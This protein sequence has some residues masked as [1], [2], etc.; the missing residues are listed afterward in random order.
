MYNPVHKQRFVVCQWTGESF[1]ES[2]R[3]LVPEHP[4]VR[5]QRSWTGCYGSPGAAVSGIKERSERIGLSVD[6][7]HELIDEFETSLSRKPG[8]GNVKFTIVAA[9]DYKNLVAFGGTQ[10]IEDFH[11]LYNHDGQ[12]E[13]YCQEIP[14]SPWCDAAAEGPVPEPSKA[15]ASAPK[16][17][18]QRWAEA[19]YESDPD[20]PANAPKRCCQ[21]SFLIARALRLPMLKVPDLSITLAPPASLTMKP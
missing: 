11:K 12:V 7:I 5:G 14:N 17:V 19:E 4:K 13:I 16:S 2:Q 18:A 15:P 1:P 20:R 21:R 10:S 3:F 6:Q 9:P 8:K